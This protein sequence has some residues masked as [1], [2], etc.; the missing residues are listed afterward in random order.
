MT[1]EAVRPLKLSEMQE[2][3]RRIVGSIV[4]TPLVRLD[5]GSGFPDIRLKLENL[6]PTNSYKLRGAVNAVAML[7]EAERKLGVWT[8]SAGNAGQGVAYAARQAEVPC[9]VVAIETA[10]TAK[11]DRMRALGAKLVLVPYETAWRALGERSYPGVM[12][13]FIHPFDDHNFIAGHSTMGLEILEDAPDTAVIIAAIGGG[14]LITGVASAAKALKPAIKIWGAEPETAAPAA[15]SF[16]VGSA[17]VFK[18]WKASFVDGAGGQSLFPRMWERI[19]TVVDGSIVVSLQETQDAMRM[20][21][22]KARIVAEGAGSLSLAAA[23]SGR[24]GDGTI[25]AVV[26]GGNIDLPKFCELIGRPSS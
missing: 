9:T 20:M 10:P 17:Q 26:S 1:L 5:L 22:E 16:S 4:R 12:G 3:R 23:L 13:T 18:D 11:I 21:A 6:Q 8:I 19:K 14:G 7:D 15:L 24:A 2:A 25:V